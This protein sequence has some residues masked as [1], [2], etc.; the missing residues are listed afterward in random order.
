MTRLLGSPQ[1][2]K[3]SN[4]AQVLIFAL[5]EMQRLPCATSFAVCHISAECK[6]A[7]AVCQGHTANR[8]SPVVSIILRV[9]E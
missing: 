1:S 6:P 3:K 4:P 9:K 2:Q 7:F 5:R 8:H